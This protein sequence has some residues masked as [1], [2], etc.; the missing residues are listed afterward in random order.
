MKGCLIFLFLFQ[1]NRLNAQSDIPLLIYNHQQW[2]FENKGQSGSI[3]TDIDLVDSWKM[4]TGGKTITG[5]DIVVAVIDGGVYMNHPDLSENIWSN[6]NEVDGN[7]LDD[8]NN[9]FIDDMHGWN[10]RAGNNDVTNEGV[11][12]HHGT[13]VN[14]I[15]GAVGYNKFGVSGIN[16]SVKLLNLIKGEDT[17][18]ILNCHRYVLNLRKMF[19]STNGEKGAFIVAIN[20]SWGL[21]SLMADDYSVWCSLYDELG[22]EGVLTVN[23][24]PNADIDVDIYGDMPVTCASDFII[25][26]TN[27]NFYDRRI[28]WSGYGISSVDLAAPGD[29]TYTIRNTGDYG[30]FG[31]TSAAAAY[32][33]GTIALLYS[34]PSYRIADDLVNDPGNFPL[35]IKESILD[36]VVPVSGLEDHSTSGGRLN[37]FNS[38]KNLLLHYNDWDLLRELESDDRFISIYPNPSTE[39][40]VVSIE[41]S[42]E[43]DITIDLYDL[44][45]NRVD[46]IFGFLPK[47]IQSVEIPTGHLKPGT[48]FVVV[49]TAAFTEQF[50]LLKI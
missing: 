6:P 29:L 38:F 13:P 1:F 47:G 36:G 41:L 21:D 49:S 31:G 7:G 37:V 32:V 15:I 42:G 27:S 48:Y 19:N 16:Q 25:S 40:S 33:S 11:G 46:S 26:V 22:S 8:D 24:A 4:T 35:I 43:K 17:A 44:Q 23:S 28:T 39:R 50:T 18:S 3:D 14:G 20:N 9:G 45:G 12:H 10:F 34:I 5:F 2:Q 30:Y